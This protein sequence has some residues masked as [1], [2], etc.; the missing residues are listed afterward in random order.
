MRNIQIYAILRDQ[1]KFKKQRQIE[2]EYF[3]AFFLTFSHV[4]NYFVATNQVIIVKLIDINKKHY[5]IAR[6]KYKI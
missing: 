2:L 4:T 6:K 5:I 3:F 1:L